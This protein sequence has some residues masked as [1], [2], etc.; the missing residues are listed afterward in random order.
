LGNK[1]H[2]G[3]KPFNGT[4]NYCGKVGHKYAECRKR[5]SDE[6]RNKF[7]LKKEGMTKNTN[8]RANTANEKDLGTED[9]VLFA[10]ENL[11]I[12]IGECPNCSDIGPLGT[13]C[14]ECEDSGMV[15]KLRNNNANEN[16]SSD[17][18]SENENSPSA[19]IIENKVYE[20]EQRHIQQ[21]T[22]RIY[23]CLIDMGITS[24]HHMIENLV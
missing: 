2:N 18:E 14:N 19:S 15:Y 24:V 8:E 9:I 7:N 1:D 5:I 23:E 3:G 12:E 11:Q 21:E 13:Y 4:C 6:T 10:N 20:R 22:D 17:M 16:S